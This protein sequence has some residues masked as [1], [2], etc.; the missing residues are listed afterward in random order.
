MAVIKSAIKK[1]LNENQV[2]SVRVEVA[3]ASA[4]NRST[5]TGVY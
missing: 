3:R 1:E 5:S 4:A 2:Q